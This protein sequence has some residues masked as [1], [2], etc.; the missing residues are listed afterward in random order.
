MHSAPASRSGSGRR[1]ALLAGLTVKKPGFR[2]G[3]SFR[4]AFSD[5]G[6]HLVTVG[7]RVTVWD[8]AERKRV[9][10]V[11]PFSHE[12]EAD[13]S[14]DSC[15]LVVKNTLGDVVVLE[16][17]TLA[18]RIRLP[19]KTYG[20]GAAIRFS[21][22]GAFLVDGS[23]AGDLLVRDATSGQVVFHEQV[24]SVRRLDCSRDRMRWLYTAEG[25]GLVTRLWPFEENDPVPIPSAASRLDCGWGAMLS[26]DGALLARATGVA[27]ET[28]QV[29]P[30]NGHWEQ[31]GRCEVPISGSGYAL[32]WHPEA[33]I[34]AYAA[35]G[36]ALLLTADAA[37]IW[38]APGFE[39]GCDATF[40]R[41]G[42]LL[43]VG[44]WSKGA[45]L[46]LDQLDLI[47]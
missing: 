19:G 3:A 8:V 33:E 22:C 43:A 44:D 13:V 26:D 25:M 17:E 46:A 23:W 14:P 9:A 37:P 6:I 24:G 39:Y 21:P 35:S 16:R 42:D 29:D 47:A 7:K 18:E 30:E 40:S 1:I 34:V 11:H 10:S 45:V 4:A 2:I 15:W 41:D 32:A 5:D 31:R 27:I 20:E 28:W 12:L 36:V 38:W